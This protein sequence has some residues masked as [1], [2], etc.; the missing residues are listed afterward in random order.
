MVEPDAVERLYPLTLNEP[1]A[2][3]EIRAVFG[4]FMG[5]AGAA[6]LLLDLRYNKPREASMV[7][8]TMMGGLSL[9]R[10]VGFVYEGFPTGTVLQET[11]FEV[12]LFIFLVILGAYRRED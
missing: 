10:I 3:S 1:M 11:I 5:G 8:A 9:A 6:L 7:L 12:V 2:H 4:G